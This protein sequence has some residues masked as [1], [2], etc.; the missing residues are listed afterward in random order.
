MIGGDAAVVTA[1]CKAYVTPTAAT[2]ATTAA[3]TLA[4]CVRAFQPC[5]LG[6][7][8]HYNYVEPRPLVPGS[9]S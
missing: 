2:V 7:V 3:A 4:P 9:A 8:I 1:S 6:E 5:I